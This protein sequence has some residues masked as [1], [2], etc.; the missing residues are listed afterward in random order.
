MKK[1]CATIIAIVTVGIF[2]TGCQT[3]SGPYGSAGFASGP[4]S[5]LQG[6]QAKHNTRKSYD[7]MP[8]RQDAN[9]N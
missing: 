2:V 4:W 1:M 9:P 6:K 3:A 7:A 5:E 8:Y